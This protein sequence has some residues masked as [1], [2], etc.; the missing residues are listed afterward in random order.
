MTE[1]TKKLNG[2][3]VDTSKNEKISFEQSKNSSEKML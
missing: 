3:D 2:K 1:L